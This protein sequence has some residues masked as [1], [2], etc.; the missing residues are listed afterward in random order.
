MSDLEQIRPGSVWRH[1]RGSFYLVVAVGQ[2]ANADSL[3]HTDSFQDRDDQWWKDLGWDQLLPTMDERQ[4]V[5]YTCLEDGSWW[6]R[7]VE[8]FAAVIGEDPVQRRFEWVRG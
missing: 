4:V 1:Y 2:D 8:D 5:I 7:T 6:V 3:L